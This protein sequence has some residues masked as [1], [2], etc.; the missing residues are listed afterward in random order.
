MLCADRPSRVSSRLGRR[1]AAVL[2]F[3]LT[4]GGVASGQW[5]LF[6]EEFDGRSV[7]DPSV[8]VGLNF[9]VQTVNSRISVW[10]KNQNGPFVWRNRLDTPAIFPNTQG[11]FEA[12][13]GTRIVDTKVQYDRTDGRFGL[14]GL[15]ISNPANPI[16]GTQEGIYVAYSNGEYPYPGTGS[17]FDWKRYRTVQPSFGSPSPGFINNPAAGI[18]NV[19]YR[20]DYNGMGITYRDLVYT[21][22]LEPISVPNS[23]NVQF[24]RRFKK[25]DLATGNVNLQFQDQLFFGR[26]TAELPQCAQNF[27]VPSP[28]TAPQPSYLV[29]V[30]APNG[31]N[32]TALELIMWQ[33]SASPTASP[34]PVRVLVPV[35]PYILASGS[36]PQG[37][38]PTGTYTNFP[39]D[40]GDGR[41]QQ[42]VVRN[43]RL[44]CCHTVLISLGAGGQLKNVARWYEFDLSTWSVTSPTTTAPTL[45][46]QGD[47]DLG[48]DSQNSPIHTYVPGI[49]AD[50]SDNVAIVFTRSSVN[51]RPAMCRLGR[52]VFD[53]AGTMPVFADTPGVNSSI[54]YLGQ[55]TF[56][57][58]GT[59]ANPE[60]WGDYAT[61]AIDGLDSWRFW[62]T[63]EVVDYGPIAPLVFGPR[64]ETRIHTFKVH[65]FGST[66]D[67][68]TSFPNPGPAM[69][70]NAPNPAI[71]TT[72]DL[73]ITEPNSLPSGT[74][75]LMAG[76]TVSI[77]GGVD[78][79][80]G[81]GLVYIDLTQAATATFT[82]TGNGQPTNFPIVIPFVPALIGYSQYHQVMILDPTSPTGLSFTN[83]TAITVGH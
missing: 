14:I 37:P 67:Y 5:T 16:P 1:A 51:E 61:M 38:T 35:A 60:R 28:T 72:V 15:Q 10:G 48:V 80:L 22:N 31:T 53:P 58:S 83:A 2:C 57:I 69:T 74:V 21:G 77:P 30:S 71:G 66:Y 56:P 81:G 34:T 45:F 55:S 20:S 36:A 12:L 78:P 40:A 49:S 17:A 50:V 79:G 6:G 46:Q 4:C 27:D 73:V 33:E 9:V 3:L 39:V 13:G 26:S 70:L 8:A 42:A 63:S 25:A 68:G 59:L 19:L 11:F 24:F 44:Y 29:G 7:P 65:R 43:G 75:A 82:L 54:V 76:S 23:P 18:N 47:I 32:G 62:C 52:R 41:I 64:W